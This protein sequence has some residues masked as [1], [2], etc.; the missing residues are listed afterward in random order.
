MRSSLA[1]IRRAILAYL[2]RNPEAADTVDGI[3][4]W[5][6][7]K[8]RIVDVKSD[9]Q[10]VLDKLAREGLLLARRAGDG[11]VHYRANP[12]HALKGKP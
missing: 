5:W 12:Q 6:L 10:K 8:Q 11:K 4:E 2:A 9:V 1:S 7:W 3:A